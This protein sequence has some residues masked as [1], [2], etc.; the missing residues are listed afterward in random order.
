MCDFTAIMGQNG[1]KIGLR[2]K[3]PVTLSNI[4]QAGD[5][6]R[7]IDVSIGTTTSETHFRTLDEAVDSFALSKCIRSQTNTNKRQRVDDVRTDLRPIAFVR[8]NS[9]QGKPKPV[10][11]RAL[12]NSGGGG[13]LVTAEFAKK[14]RARRSNTQQVWT[15][16]SGSMTTNSKVQ[17]QFTIPE[18]HDNRVIEWDVHVTKSLGAH[19]IIIDRDLLQFLGIDALFSSLTIEWDGTSMPFKEQDATILDSYHTQDP[20]AVEDQAT[21][22]KEILDAKYEPADLEECNKANP[23]LNPNQQGRCWPC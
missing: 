9:R 8:F 23:E 16:P 14:L 6:M 12:L 21:R 15:T 18:L 3:N 13:T 1:G 7:F 22:V 10:T 11:L 2:G 4:F 19:D 5:I 17:T 20:Q